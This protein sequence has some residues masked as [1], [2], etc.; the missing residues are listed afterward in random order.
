MNL[1]RA[2]LIVQLCAA[3]A[4]ASLRGREE[5]A[6]AAR[7]LEL[8]QE[9][10]DK[11]DRIIGGK[12]AREGRYS[13]AVS[14]EDRD[15]QFCGGSLIAPDVVLSAAHC[16][17]GKY[18]AVIGRHDLRKNDGDE[19]DIEREME[20]PGYDYDEDDGDFM[21]LFLK[22]PTSARVELVEVGSDFVNAGTKVTVVGR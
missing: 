12:E 14:L 15:G 11:D 20:W 19:V 1:P 10:K 21:L 6:V 8:E 22:R 4:S 2:A 7:P 3:R 9:P 17:G 5:R 16:S 13:Y 18:K